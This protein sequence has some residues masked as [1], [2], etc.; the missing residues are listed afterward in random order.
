MQSYN[1][2]NQKRRRYKEDSFFLSG[3]LYLEVETRNNN[4]EIEKPLLSTK[5]WARPAI[6]ALQILLL[7]LVLARPDITLFILKVKNM[8]TRESES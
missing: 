3:N 4:I 6:D 2:I 5:P 1:S 7:I 8:R